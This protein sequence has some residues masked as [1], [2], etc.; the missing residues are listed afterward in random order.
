MIQ[1]ALHVY[2]RSGKRQDLK[3]E[4]KGCSRPF[5]ACA[6]CPITLEDVSSHRWKMSPSSTDLHWTFLGTCI[7]RVLCKHKR[8]HTQQIMK[9]VCGCVQ[10]S[11]F[12]S[13]I[14]WWQC[15]FDM[16]T[17]LFFCVRCSLLSFHKRVHNY[18]DVCCETF[19]VS[20]WPFQLQLTIEN[21]WK[22]AMLICLN[23]LN[24]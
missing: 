18:V 6:L 16:Q 1:F 19:C 9:C 17:L 7:F 22:C 8:W 20:L 5:Y 2:L 3:Y 11:T 13:E 10:F 23:V 21:V 14:P 4:R 12:K 24:A 15:M